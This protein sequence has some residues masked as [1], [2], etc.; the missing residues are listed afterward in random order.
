MKMSSFRTWNSVIDKP[1]FWRW[2]TLRL[3]R[4]NYQ[5]VLRSLCR[6]IDVDKNASQFLW[7]ISDLEISYLY[8]F[9]YVLSGPGIQLLKNCSGRSGFGPHRFWTEGTTRRSF[10]AFRMR[11]RMIETD[12]TTSR[13]SILF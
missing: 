9:M 13:R 4:G 11:M 10:R 1:K 12:Y 5:E 7:Y 6:G 8:S 2:A 3:D